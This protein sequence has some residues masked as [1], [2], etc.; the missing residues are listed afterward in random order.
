MTVKEVIAQLQKIKDPTMPIFIDCP[1]CGHALEFRKL[2]E[3]V[4]IEARMGSQS[5]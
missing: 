3:I 5:K 1:H 2:K 4:L